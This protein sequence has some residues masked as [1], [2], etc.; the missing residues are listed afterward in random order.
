MSS[1]FFQNNFSRA[2]AQAFFQT[3]I[4]ETEN[5]ASWQART[6]SARFAV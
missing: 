3:P 4:C 2:D 1:G 6:G 5:T